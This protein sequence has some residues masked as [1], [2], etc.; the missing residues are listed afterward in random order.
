MAHIITL[1]GPAHCGK[2]TIRQ[3]FLDLQKETFVPIMVKKFTTRAQRAND[4]DV[5]CVSK[6][7]KGCDLVY[8]QYG[9]RYGMR[10]EE[11]YKHL[12]AGKTPIVVVNDIRAVEDI[13]SALGSLVYSVFLYRKA[14]TYEEFYSEEKE[15]YPERTNEEIEGSA[16]TRFEKAQAIYRI[17]IENIQLFDKVILNT[18]DK[19]STKKQIECI[20]KKF[21]SEF[22]D[23]TLNMPIIDDN[24]QRK[25]RNVIGTKGSECL[26][27]K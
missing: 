8:E 23:F 22:A 4:D 24:S 17:Y 12:E 7:P 26:G 2:S 6:I 21:M 18:F 16:R 10:M 9:V 20:V 27:N 11:L 19:N 14:A 13:K 3:M 25:H 5:I 1:T 15:R